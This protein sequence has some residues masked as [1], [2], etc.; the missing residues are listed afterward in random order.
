MADYFTQFSCSLDVGSADNVAAALAL[1]GEYTDE[2]DRNDEGGI[3]FAAERLIGADTAIWIHDDGQGDVEHV[4]AF[5]QRCGQA[6]GLTGRWGFQYA[7]TCSRA[8]LD[9]FGGGAHVLDLATGGTV[10]WTDT[11][12]WLASHLSGAE[13]DHA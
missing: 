3:G 6:F 10:S 12:G 5:V 11:N 4:L 9:G 8:R 2:P 1:N 13:A 7:N